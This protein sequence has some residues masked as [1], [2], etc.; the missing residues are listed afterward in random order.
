M[1]DGPAEGDWSAAQIIEHV[2]S[3]ERNY[4]DR[5]VAGLEAVRAAANSTPA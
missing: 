5:L 1:K 3:T 2:T 4:R